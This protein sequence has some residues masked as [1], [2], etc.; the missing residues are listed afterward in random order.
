MGRIE[1]G[2]G[3]V[4]VQ[5]IRGSRFDGV[6]LYT[7]PTIG[8]G[9]AVSP[10][11]AVEASAFLM[12]PVNVVGV[13]GEGMDPKVAFPHF[14]VQGTVLFGDFTRKRAASQPLP[15]GEGGPLAIPGGRPPPSRDRSRTRPRPAP[16]APAPRS[17]PD[18]PLR[19]GDLPPAGDEDDDPPLAIPN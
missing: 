15:P 11:A 19:P 4:G 17:Q 8:A 3:W 5:S 18:E 9:V 1:K 2:A 14:G 16:A 10:W 13:V 12:L 6:F 7:R